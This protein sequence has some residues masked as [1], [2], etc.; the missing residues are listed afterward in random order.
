MTEATETAT[1]AA[2]GMRR[3]MV[4][5]PAGTQEDGSGRKYRMGGTGTE[6]SAAESVNW[7]GEETE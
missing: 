4:D 6:K 3:T 5:P 1:M 2:I 7:S